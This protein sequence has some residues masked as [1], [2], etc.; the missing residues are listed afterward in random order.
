MGQIGEP[1][2]VLTETGDRRFGLSWI[3]TVQV[4]SDSKEDIQ[5]TI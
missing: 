3:T 4:L 2:Q 5:S 1:G